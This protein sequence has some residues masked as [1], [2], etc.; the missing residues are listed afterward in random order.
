M[1][2]QRICSTSQSMK[3]LVLREK[4]LPFN[5]AEFWKDFPKRGKTFQKLVLV[6]F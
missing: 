1:R 5:R 3:S 2:A 4:Q 6:R